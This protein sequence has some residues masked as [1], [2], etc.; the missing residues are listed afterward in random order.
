M[1]GSWGNSHIDKKKNQTSFV[2]KWR[3]QEP[4]CCVTGWYEVLT[5]SIFA[6]V[7]CATSEL[8]RKPL[9]LIFMWRSSKTPLISAGFLRSTDPTW[10]W[11]ADVTHEASSK[12]LLVPQPISCNFM[13][14]F[15]P[16]P[17]KPLFAS[18]ISHQIRL[19]VYAAPAGRPERQDRASGCSYRSHPTWCELKISHVATRTPNPYLPVLPKK[20]RTC[21]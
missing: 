5:S 4:E 15:L 9:N 13:F 10:G 3:T 18:S 20:L 8:I 12:T 17:D 19:T 7:V 14:N 21:C 16:T 6:E 2:K 1:S 11:G